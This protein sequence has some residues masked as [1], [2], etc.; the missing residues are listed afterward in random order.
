MLALLAHSPRDIWNK[1]KKRGRTHSST[2]RGGH[3]RDPTGADTTDP[4]LHQGGLRPLAH[5]KEGRG[6]EAVVLLRARALDVCVQVGP[7]AVRDARRDRLTRIETN[8]D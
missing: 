2:V 1:K 6:E 7:L 5:H 8:F 4:R 3:G